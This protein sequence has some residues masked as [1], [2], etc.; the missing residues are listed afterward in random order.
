MKK[1][2]VNL[3]IVLLSTVVL[4][5]LGICI[6]LIFFW[7]ND[8]ISYHMEKSRI[9]ATCIESEYDY[10]DFF[11]KSGN[12]YFNY[13]VIDS[14][15]ESIVAL[16]KKIVDDVNSY[17]KLVE[18]NSV[19]EA[20]DDTP[21]AKIKVIKGNTIYN[22]SHLYTI[23]FDVIES[24]KYL[25][26][27]EYDA[28]LSTCASGWTDVSNIFIYDK[29]EDKLISQNEL[30]LVNEDNLKEVAFKGRLNDSADIN[31]YENELNTI[32]EEHKYFLYYL[33]NGSIA[34]V[35]SEPETSGALARFSYENDSWSKMVIE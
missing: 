4:I 2:K 25:S 26:I 16:N 10:C 18:N 27:I 22:D 3:K 28:V 29:T 14:N 13:P 24:N 32:I 17:I 20:L 31:T 33:E 1:D 30:S 15:K 7:K 19:K 11:D 5:L 8:S 12:L 35:F 21:C 34:I 23:K 9:F 6:Y